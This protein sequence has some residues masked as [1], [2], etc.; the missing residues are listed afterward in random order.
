VTLFRIAAHIQVDR[1]FGFESRERFQVYKFPVSQLQFYKQTIRVSEI[2][3]YIVQE[4]TDHARIIHAYQL[5]IVQPR[6]CPAHDQAGA[7]IHES[8]WKHLAAAE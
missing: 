3:R 1:G 5:G 7:G 4:R 8:L 6:F 2:V